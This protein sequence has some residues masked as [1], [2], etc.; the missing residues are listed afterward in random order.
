LDDFSEVSQLLFQTTVL[1]QYFEGNVL[2]TTE[3]YSYYDIKVEPIFGPIGF[4][5]MWADTARGF[6]EWKSILIT[7]TGN[8]FRFME[9][10]DWTVEQTMDCQYA[11]VIL[12]ASDEH[13]Q[14]V[15]KDFLFETWNVTFKKTE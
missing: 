14:L 8:D 6:S 1:R 2:K 4:G 10:F 15:N 11:R 9:F 5:A 7:S 12:I 13:P 3:T